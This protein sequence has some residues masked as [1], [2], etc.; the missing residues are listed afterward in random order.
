MLVLK[1]DRDG[2]NI[3][4]ISHGGVMRSIKSVE[5]G[6]RPEEHRDLRLNANAKIEQVDISA[7]RRSIG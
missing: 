7:I 3:L 1:H 5:L 2:K 6:M 4:F